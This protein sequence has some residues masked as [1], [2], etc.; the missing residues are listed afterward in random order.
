MIK[1]ESKVGMG[2]SSHDATP[3]VLEFILYIIFGHFTSLHLEELHV[4]V[5]YFMLE[6]A[7]FC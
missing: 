7:L 4:L 2:E 6:T 3:S 1:L 5:C